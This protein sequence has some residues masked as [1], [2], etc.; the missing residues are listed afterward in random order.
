MDIRNHFSRDLIKVRMGIDFPNSK[1]GSKDLYIARFNKQNTFSKNNRKYGWSDFKD[2]GILSKIWNRA[3]ENHPLN[4]VLYSYYSDEASL[5]SETYYK[6]GYKQGIS[7]WWYKNGN[8]KKMCFFDDFNIEE[9]TQ[10]PMYI[11]TRIINEKE[12]TKEYEKYRNENG[13]SKP[14]G[15][16]REFYSNGQLKKLVR[17]KNGKEISV[18]NLDENG[19][20]LVSQEILENNKYNINDTWECGAT[21]T[22]TK[23]T[24]YLS[25]NNP[26]TPINGYVFDYYNNNNSQLKS[27]GYYKNGVKQ[28]RH[29]T[30]YEN[31]QIRHEENFL[32]GLFH[33]R[34]KSYFENG[35]LRFEDNYLLGLSHDAHKSWDENGQLKYETN[36][37]DGL[38]HGLNRGWDENG[39][40]INDFIF[41]EDKYISG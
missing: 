33:G 10:I 6:D 32:D 28:G 19:K 13:F 18:I 36:Y 29:R 39:Q 40:L 12:R 25:I 3:I 5:Y 1:H 41:F 16:S 34:S 21:G 17:Y 23:G 38:K 4:G 2:G 22:Y 37:L 15:I 27:E 11:T 26:M 31:G 30:L 7:R 8:L 9:N 24:R 20:E 14:V 35:Q